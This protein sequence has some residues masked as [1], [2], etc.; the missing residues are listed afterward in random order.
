MGILSRIGVAIDSELLERF[1]RLIAQRGYTNRSEAFR[2]LIRDELVERAWESPESHV[3]GT[4]TLVYD[5]H[6][7]LLN[8]KLTSLQHDHHRAILSTL[9]VHLDHDH[10]LEVLVVKGRAAEVQ[11]IADALI[12][13]KGVKHGRLTITT[14]GSELK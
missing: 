13:T 11:Q 7:R 9:H 12:S 10:C 2:D 3:V 4:V 1:D 14:S 5:H 8:E 6:V